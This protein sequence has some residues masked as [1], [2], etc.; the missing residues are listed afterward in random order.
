MPAG[1]APLKGI[2]GAFFDTERPAGL[3]ERV[4]ASLVHAI[5]SG[6]F[7]KGDK[8]P[9]EPRLAT[10]FGVSRPVVRQALEKLRGDGMIESLRGSGNY[11]AG[12]DH[13]VST[14]RTDSAAWTTQAKAMMDD[15]EFRI[16]V[17]PEAAYWAARRRGQA[18]LNS[19]RSALGQF[20]EAH[21]AGRIT[22]HFDYLFH[23]A[24][25]IA[26]TNARFIEAARS[27]EYPKD[28]DRLLMRHL[29][30]FH[31]VRRG[32]EFIREHQRVF[33]LIVERDP[34]AARDAMRSHIGA[35]RNRLSEQIEML[36][37]GDL[38][39]NP[40]PAIAI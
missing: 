10:T 29:T 14:I 38:A 15:L 33:E 18:D 12:L 26:T 11:V 1:K 16:T 39:P 21:A 3:H 31:P 20:E 37:R 8:L 19:M 22:H 32:S 4:H 27:V 5:I 28:A 35:S 34:E 24:I 2:G 13:L 9:S 7:A 30:Y 17:E 36:R 40:R 23:E 6:R 25:A